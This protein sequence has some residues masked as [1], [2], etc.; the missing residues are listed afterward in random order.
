[1]KLFASPLH[2][3]LLCTSIE[4]V[5]QGL[6]TR[7]QHIAMLLVVGMKLH[8][9]NIHSVVTYYIQLYRYWKWLLYGYW[10]WLLYSH[11]VTLTEQH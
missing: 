2:L 7:L 1:M 6:G 5:G 10:K 3:S 4:K 11:N 9:Q 8:P